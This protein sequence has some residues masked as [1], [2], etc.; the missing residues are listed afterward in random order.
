VLLSLDGYN[1]S[2]L[3]DFSFRP[4][5]SKSLSNALLLLA[6]AFPFFTLGFEDELVFPLAGTLILEG[7]PD[8]FADRIAALTPPE[9]P[10]SLSSSSVILRRF[11]FLERPENLSLLGYSCESSV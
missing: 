9:S 8:L 6:V 7:R 11:A 2:F 1:F 3:P 4:C 5:P 10:I